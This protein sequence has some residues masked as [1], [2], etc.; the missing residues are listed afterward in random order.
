MDVSDEF[1]DLVN[2]M[3]QPDPEMRLDMADI[4]V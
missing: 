2:G 1:M 4:L 3:I